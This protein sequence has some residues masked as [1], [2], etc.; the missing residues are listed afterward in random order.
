MALSTQKTNVQKWVIYWTLI[1]S[2][3]LTRILLVSLKT[4]YLILRVRCSG[5]RLK[6]FYFGN[7][8]AFG[9]QGMHKNLWKILR[10]RKHLVDLR[11]G[12]GIILKWIISV[13]IIWIE[14]NLYFCSQRPDI[15]AS[16][17]LPDFEANLW[18]ISRLFLSAIKDNTRT[19]TP[20]STLNSKWNRIVALP[21]I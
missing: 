2:L 7:C 20:R 4:D 3:L 18:P 17:N 12:V 6:A 14:L 1:N 9:T 11:I 13:L 19:H 16:L 8:H 21:T 10:L 15:S 5:V